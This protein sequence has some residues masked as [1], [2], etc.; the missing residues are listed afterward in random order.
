[1]QWRDPI[2]STV[3]AVLTVI[4]AFGTAGT[5]IVSWA[6]A[7]SWFDIADTHVPA[8]PVNWVFALIAVAVTAYIWYLSVNRKNVNGWLLVAVA[9]PFVIAFLLFTVAGK[10]AHLPAVSLLTG[11][12]A[13]A[14]PLVFGA[15]S[16]VVNERSGIINI[17][18]EGQLLFGAF[19]GAIVASIAG[20]PYLGLIGAPIAGALVGALLA[21]FTINFRTDHIIVGV[22]LNM[23]VVGLTSFLFSTVL[24]FNA[25]QLNSINRLPNLKIPVLS[26]IPVIGPILFNQSLLVYI[27]FITVIVLQY[28]VFNSR[29]GLRMRACGE[30]PRA[31]DTVGIRVNRTRWMNVLLGGALAGMGGAFF[32]I[33]QGLAFSKDMAAGNGFIALAAMILGRW[34]PKGAFGAAL[35][36]GFATNLGATM[37]AVGSDVPSEFLLMIPYIITILAVA[38][39]VGSVRAPAAEGKPYP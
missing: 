20:N 39:F 30:H 24:K 3:M 5:A 23:L 36:F 13:F 28:M 34:N 12:L 1:M 38:G 4:I 29:W 31:A 33:G 6:G 32:T 19:M 15:L 35:L 26:D 25:E 21:L 18:I 9:V 2:A 37:Q 17:A 27:M 7:T 8:G 10:G 14:T 22:V 11:A 16:G